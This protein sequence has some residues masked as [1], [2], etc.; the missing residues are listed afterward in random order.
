MSKFTYTEEE[1]KILK[2][3]AD[4]HTGMIIYPDK[5][6][7]VNG[8]DK[9]IVGIYYFENP[10]DYEPYG[11]YDLKEFLSGVNLYNSELEIHDK[12]INISNSKQ[13]IS[14]KY[15]NTSLDMLPEAKDLS[16][17]FN[18]LDSELEFVLTAEKYAIMK[19][20]IQVFNAEKIYFRT[21]DS[22]T[23]RVVVASSLDAN[24]KQPELQENATEIIITGDNVIKSEL[25]EDTVLY[26][27]VDEFK[28]MD[29]DYDVKISS[30][31][32][33]KWKH[34]QIKSLQYFIGVANIDED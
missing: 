13:G 16:E 34:K 10:Y 12:Y 3:F 30:A 27:K 4:I 15:R 26:I 14:T 9:S 24:N 1:N 32:A 18:K 33:S 21:V 20:V 17:A 25:P 19:K 6:M 8:L 29:G 11:V 7:V 23:I 5:F 2:N 31:K 22:S 28:L